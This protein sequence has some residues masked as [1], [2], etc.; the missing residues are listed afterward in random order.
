M[1]KKARCYYARRF[2]RSVPAMLRIASTPVEMTSQMETVVA[3]GFAQQFVQANDG[4][5][6]R[7]F[8]LHSHT[9]KRPQ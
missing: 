3:D 9:K 7:E 2:L 8:L 5:I 4:L 1:R 6:I